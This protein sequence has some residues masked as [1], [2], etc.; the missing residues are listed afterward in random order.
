MNVLLLM[1]SACENTK[2]EFNPQLRCGFRIFINFFLRL[3]R[4]VAG[5]VSA[6]LVT[7]LLIGITCLM[8]V[9]PETRCKFMEDNLICV[10]YSKH[11]E[12]FAMHDISQRAPYDA[13][14]VRAILVDNDYLQPLD[15][16]LFEK[17]VLLHTPS[18]SHLVI[19]ESKI[20]YIPNMQSNTELVHF[21]ASF[22]DIERIQAFDFAGTNLY[23]L[24]LSHN[25][26]ATINENAFNVRQLNVIRGLNLTEII[27]ANNRLTRALP[28]WFQFLKKLKK[29]DLRNNL[30]AAVDNQFLLSLNRWNSLEFDK[31]IANNSSAITRNYKSKKV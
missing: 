31:F 22:N 6:F 3:H 26:I 27:L 25:K 12:W 4:V 19:R 28:E 10:P 14:F 21:N 5:F 8:N 7:T 16:H 11:P 2:S 24:D 9:V 13:L 17:N 1:K 29:I 18:L 30:I 15:L 23:S 20:T